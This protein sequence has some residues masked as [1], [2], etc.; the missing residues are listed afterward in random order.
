MTEAGIWFLIF[1]G[2]GAVLI[3]YLAWC[4]L[5]WAFVGAV[6]LFGHAVGHGFLGFAVYVILW[7]VALPVMLIICIALGFFISM[8]ASKGK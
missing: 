5:C 1:G 7:V 2:V 8:A 3:L 6:Q 4:L